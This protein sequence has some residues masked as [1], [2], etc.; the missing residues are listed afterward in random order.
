MEQAAAEAWQAARPGRALG[1]RA[2]CVAPWVSLELDP[3]GW[4]YGCCANQLYPLGRIGR[5]R[6]RDLWGGPRAQVLREA[7]DRWDLSVG[8][9][10]CRWHLEHGRMDPD[11][12]VYDRYP[13]DGDAPAGPVAMTFALSNRCN[14]GC[15]MCTPELSST[16]R[17][18]AGLAPLASPYDDEFYEDLAAFLP[19][20]AY[21]KFLGG[22]PFLIPEHHRVWDLMDE[23][24]GPPRMQVTTNGTVWTDRVAY[25]LERF[26]VDV[27]VSIDGATAPTYEAVRRGASF[28]AVAANLARFAAACDRAGTELRLCFCLMPDNHH[29]LAAMVRWADDLGAALSVN[30]VSDAGLALH[31]LPVADLEAVRARWADQAAGGFGANRPV[32]DVQVAQ[33]EA[34]LAERRAGIGPAARQAQP[35]GP[36]LLAR[37][38]PDPDGPTWS[39]ADPDP[40]VVAAERDR[41]DRWSG[42]G[43]V[44]ELRLDADDRVAA[45]PAGHERLGLGGSLV[46]RSVDDVL[47]AMA[48]AD[49]RAPW[50]VGVDPDRIGRTVRTVVLAAERPVRGV[51]GAIVRLVALGAADGWALLAAE[52]RI[53]ERP[54]PVAV[55]APAVRR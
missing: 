48:E 28:D 19:G 2:A 3:S 9:G 35:A 33:L 13:V 53:Y 6:L 21:A 41:L 26:A 14:L 10:S 17:R 8:C 47:A 23:V 54:G 49:G 46:G 43:P 34:V 29:E 37:P 18:E 44:A 4:V 30:V 7:L 36:G 27:T 24:G 38:D 45:V 1:H 32:W 16:L 42:G 51:E 12:A 22:E 11:A 39:I 31:D 50:V 55:A 5:D 40:E 15:A 20:L 25:L 52:D